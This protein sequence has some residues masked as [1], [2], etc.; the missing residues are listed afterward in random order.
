MGAAPHPL[1]RG[2]THL[3]RVR[4]IHQ[5]VK[6]DHDVFFLLLVLVLLL[7]LRLLLRLLFTGG[8]RGRPRPALAPVLHAVELG[9]G[10]QRQDG[11]RVLLL[12]QVCAA[13]AMVER[14]CCRSA[15]LVVVAAPTR[16]HEPRRGGASGRARAK[17]PLPHRHL[18]DGTGGMR[19]CRLR[20]ASMG[21][22]GKA[23]KKS[24]K[25]ER[26]VHLKR[27]RIVQQATA[28]TGRRRG[29]AGR[30]ADQ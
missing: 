15:V 16:P 12:V 19:P 3:L 7:V 27:S 17:A 8:A 10:G 9:R 4:D 24:S 28:A 6:V 20:S 14:W 13:A 23:E 29:A 25:A 21:K 1:T 26:V 2:A 30:V 5:V 22:P 11:H 18:G